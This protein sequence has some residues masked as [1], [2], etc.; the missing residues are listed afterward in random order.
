MH[1]KYLRYFVP[2]IALS[3]IAIVIALA[4]FFNNN[5]GCRV[6]V[7]TEKATRLRVVENAKFQT[8][9]ENFLPCEN[10]KYL[11]YTEN[12]A[13]QKN[14]VK[15]VKYIFTSSQQTNNALLNSDGRIDLGWNNI[16]KADD[17]SLDI[18]IYLPTY[19]NLENY[20]MRLYRSFFIIT[21]KLKTRSLTESTEIYDKFPTLESIGLS[22]ER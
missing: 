3:L 16:Y 13:M 18:L 21:N 10:D 4:S 12:G 7:R 1:R 17:Q 14:E 2:F 9:F 20:D 8:F 15:N 22:Y 19:G 11:I 6:E 5:K